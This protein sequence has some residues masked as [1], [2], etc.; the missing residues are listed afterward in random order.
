VDYAG[1]PIDGATIPDAFGQQGP[2][3]TASGALQYIQDTKERAV[4]VLRD[5]HTYLDDQVPVRRGLRDVSRQLKGLPKEIAR[6]VILLSP[7]FA[8]HAELEADVHVMPWPL[9]KREE[10][11]AVLEKA[12]KNLPVDLQKAMTA[13]E[14]DHI[15]EAA[16]GLTVEEASSSFARSIVEKGKLDPALIVRE[17]KQKVA[18]SGRT[19][20]LEPFENGLAALGDL[21][22]FKEWAADRYEYFGI[23]AREYGMPTPK[24]VVLAGPAGCGKTALARALAGQWH[25]PAFRMNCAAQ[26]SS[27][28]GGSEGNLLSD[29][30]LFEACAP[31]IVLI[32]EFDEGIGNGQS[33]NQVENRQAGEIQTWL[34]TRTA[35]VFVMA[36]TNNI[37]VVERERPQLVR[38]GRFDAK[39]YVPLPSEAGRKMIFDVHISRVKK[40]GT[41][42]TTLL[43]L[44]TKGFSGAEIEAV[45]DDA[46]GRAFRDGKRPLTTEDVLME[47]KRT[48]PTSKSGAE[49]NKAIEDFCRGKLMWASREASLPGTPSNKTTPEGDREIEVA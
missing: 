49:R 18:K 12:M 19:E 30:A 4:Y 6:T 28:H 14:K 13:T 38:K 32:D 29:I 22:D 46:K 2:I 25:M 41:V 8:L 44:A 43:A 17:K 40:L 34:S 11:A 15:V 45:V 10:L 48:I 42:D 5:F 24:G 9:P 31:C 26:Q 21:E 33:I 37:D 23:D 3:R 35:P 16:L 1:D 27:L 20:W 36:T 47:A 7:I 39:W